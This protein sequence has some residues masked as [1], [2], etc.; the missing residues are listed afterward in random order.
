MGGGR[1]WGGTGKRLSKASWAANQ[2]GRK[3][4][5]SYDGALSVLIF[6]LDMLLSNKGE[7]NMKGGRPGWWW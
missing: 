4:T 3:E 6:V 5:Q 1:G 7:E 2:Q